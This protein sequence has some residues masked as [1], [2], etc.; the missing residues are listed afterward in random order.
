M[1]IPRAGSKFANRILR[2]PIELNWRRVSL[3]MSRPSERFAR[4]RERRRVCRRQVAA[5]TELQSEF[6]PPSW[7]SRVVAA[8]C[9]KGRHAESWNIHPRNRCKQITRRSSVLLARKTALQIYR[10]RYR[11]GSLVSSFVSSSSTS[12]KDYLA[13]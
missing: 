1:Q 11:K 7:D 2:V 6:T 12:G 8:G 3:A 13:R 5:N 4:S 9:H 10:R